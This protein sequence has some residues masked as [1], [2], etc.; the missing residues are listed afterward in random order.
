MSRNA[1]AAEE[2]ELYFRLA[3][4][5]GSLGLFVT[6][7][8]VHRKNTE[9]RTSRL[10][11]ELDEAA[12]QK[13]AIIQQALTHLSKSQQVWRV[14]GESATSDWKRHA[15][16]SALVRRTPISVGC[17]MPPRVETNIA[18]PCINL[19]KVRLFFLPDVILYWE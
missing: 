4:L 18:I 5:L 15:G 9:K 10:F 13:F 16:A 2:R 1:A 8:V 3:P 11:Y 17:S 14:E 19:G 12:L 6:G 7:I